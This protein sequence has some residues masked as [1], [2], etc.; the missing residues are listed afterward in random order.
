MIDKREV[1]KK[2]ALR[3]C[4]GVCRDAGELHGDSKQKHV[5]THRDKMAPT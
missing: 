2:D 4:A 1:G 5:A 3:P